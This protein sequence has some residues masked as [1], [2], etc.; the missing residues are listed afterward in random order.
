M[1]VRWRRVLGVAAGGLVAL[2]VVAGVVV[3]ILAVPVSG[4]SMS[5]TFADGDRLLLRPFDGPGDVRRGDVVAVRFTENGPLVV[6][7]VIAVAGDRVRIDP[8][9]VVR[10][11]RAGQTDW[12]VVPT[13]GDWG[14]KPV[15]CCGLDGAAS[16]G[17][18]D[19]LVPNKMLFVLGDNPSGSDDSRTFGWAPR[20]RVRGIVWTKVWP[21]G[22]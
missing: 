2:V 11:L 1:R 20:E 22:G 6:K 16:P 7:R 17:S 5:P 10:L 13:P 12:E 15:A 21:L 14:T 9:P 19:V 18:A 4:S 3:A 8:G